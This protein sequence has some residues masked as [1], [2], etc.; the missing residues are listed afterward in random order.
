MVWG[1]IRHDGIRV[2][3]RCNGTGDQHEY[4]RLLNSGLP[5]IYS[6]RYFLQHD[7]AP[8]HRASKV[9]TYLADKSIRL[10]KENPPQSPDLSPI[11]NIWDIV[12]ENVIRSLLMNCGT[13]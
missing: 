5:L 6:T 10:P 3:L 12:K 7:G 13:F 1:A 11:E 8:S 2:L 4:I 9:S